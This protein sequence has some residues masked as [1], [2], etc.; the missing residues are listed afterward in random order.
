MVSRQ[1]LLRPLHGA[2][3][4]ILPLVRVVVEHAV[5]DLHIIDL[6]GIQPHHAVRR[7][8]E[9]LSRF[10]AVYPVEGPLELQLE[11][12]VVHGLEEK[13]Q[14]PYRVAP[15]GIVGH[16]GDKDNDHIGVVPADLLRGVHT[17]DLGH[18]DV[19]QDHVKYR[20]V[21]PQQLLAV[22]KAGDLD[23]LPPFLHKAFYIFLHLVL[24]T[25]FILHNG[26]VQH[27]ALHL[28]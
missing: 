16:V 1:L 9:H 18:L 27:T 26:N 7:G 5:L 11:G 21:L 12:L 17:V 10:P 22:G 25:S 2:P 13:V 19:Q 4:H 3:K 20:P 28:S 15:D 14:G 23:V 24:K 8:E 6:P